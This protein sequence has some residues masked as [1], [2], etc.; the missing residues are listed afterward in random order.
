MVLLTTNVLRNILTC[1]NDELKILNGELTLLFCFTFFIFPFQSHFPEDTDFVQVG[2]PSAPAA[3][4]P[5]EE[6][7]PRD[8]FWF[9]D[10]D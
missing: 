7:Q 8:R 10:F 5:E 9:L 4:P 2:R 6:R 3:T 1:N